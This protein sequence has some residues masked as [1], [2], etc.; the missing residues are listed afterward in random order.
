MEFQS[1]GFQ[2]VGNWLMRLARLD[3]TVFDD[4]KD[5]AAAT[6]PAIAVVVVASFLAGLGTWLWGVVEDVPDKGELLLKATILGS[7]V[8]IFLWLLWVYIAAMILSRV[9]GTGA[10]PYRMI[11]TMGLAF[12]PMAISLLVLLSVLSVPFAVIAIGATF[13]LTNAAI[14]SAT[15]AP[16]DRVALANLIGFAAF[17]IVLGIFSN[18]A[19]WGERGGLAPGIFFFNLNW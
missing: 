14:A 4:V 13:L 9:F 6:A 8:Q 12:A 2:N 17:A 10:D 15:D 5:N 16:A 18:V 11:R 3:L 19:E 1:A 7:I